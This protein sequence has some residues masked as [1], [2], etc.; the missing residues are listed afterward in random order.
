[1][2]LLERDNELHDLVEHYRQAAAGSGRLVFVSGEAGVG[3]TALIDEFRRRIAQQ[4]DVRRFSCDALSTPAPLS[5]IRDL[6]ATLGLPL[7]PETFDGVAREQLFRAILAAL[8]ARSDPIVLIAEDAHWSDGASLEILRFLGRRIDRLPVLGV[9]SYRDDEIGARH[10]LRV[11]LGDLATET[12]VHRLSML[13]LSEDAVGQLAAG[14][15]R[16]VAALFRLTGGNPFFLSEVLASAGE[17]VPTSA[18][19]AVLARASRLSAEAR[20]VVDVAAVIGSLIDLD[21]LQR[22]TGPV[23]DGIDEAVAG[24]LLRETDDGLI[25][26]HELARGAILATI[27]TPRRKLLHARVLDILR[28]SSGEGRDL[29]LLAH[30]AEAAGNRQAVLE[31]AVAAAEQAMTLHAHREAAAQYARALRFAG[32]LTLNERAHLLERQSLAFS[33]NDQGV[34]AV[35]AR[36]EAI[37]LWR[38]AGNPLAEGE[39]LRWLSRLAWLAG[40]GAEAETAATAALEVLKPLPPGPQLAMAYSNLAQLRMLD[41]DLAATLLWGERAIALADQLGETETRI[42]A[43]SSV[44]AARLYADVGG[45]EEE[46]QHSLDLALRAGRNDHAVRAMTNLAWMTL[47][48]MRLEEAERRLA[49]ALTFA[50]DHHLDPFHRYLLAGGGMLRFRQGDWDA[51]E[52]EFRLLLR[53]PELS[54]VT[55]ALAQTTLGHMLARRGHTDA[56]ALLSE[57]L[58]LARSNGQLLLLG[59]V[60]AARAEAA[61][62]EG[63]LQRARA[64]TLAVRDLVFQHGNRW[65]RGEFAWLLR[66]TGEQEIPVAIGELAAPYALQL[67]GDHVV[68]AEAWQQIGCPY[69]EARALAESDD[70]E[71]V[72]RA[73]AIFER[74]GAKPALGQANRRLRALGVHDLPVRRGPRAST[75][76]NPAGL[77]Q[78]EVEVLLLLAEGLRNAEIAERLYLSPKTVRHHVS[79]IFAK[80]GVETRTE[81]A[82][83]ATKLGLIPS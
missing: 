65:L 50:T 68:A 37:D 66:Q 59:P 48:A 83:T 80:L 62:L 32:S 61:I 52:E 47:L 15:G 31:F 70:P 81:A 49:A 64:E 39:S 14:S 11:I 21:V 10:P 36:Q 74:L 79:V 57:A 12:A 27:S 29:A 43:L 67:T 73:A 77:T 33:F 38:E 58:M 69:E 60:H 25:F 2:E 18:G 9:I 34:E 13:P 51:A 56:T 82:R 75:Q 41:H 53:Q 17:S 72:R 55:R 26:R 76:A 71:L 7:E 19:D 8:A 30:H 46:L 1:M 44:G 20:A 5:P 45:G 3:K 35:A 16:D 78:R 4:T 63:D 28:E 24:G 23:L 22:I 6:A 40:S 54:A 42:H